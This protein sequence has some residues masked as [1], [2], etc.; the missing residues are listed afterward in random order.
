TQVYSSLLYDGPTLCSVFNGVYRVS[1][2]YP[3]SEET[4]ERIDAFVESEK[5]AGNTPHVLPFK[6]AGR[7]TGTM[8]VF[9]AN[10]EALGDAELQ[11]DY[12]PLDLLRAE[13]SLSLT[14][15]EELEAR[16]ER[17]RNGNQH[18][19]HGPDLF[20]NGFS[21]GRAL[22]TSQHLTGTSVRIE[23]REFIIDDNWT[24]SVVWKIHRHGVLDKVVFGT[25]DWTPAE[26][27]LTAQYS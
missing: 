15:A 21:Y 10:Q 8:Q 16:F 18:T 24:M 20:G 6:H 3:D 22:Y 4:R 2:D 23:G 5:D 27:V 13:V 1:H 25:I 14:G 9:G 19:F 7:W 11:M 17:A 12:R 26:K